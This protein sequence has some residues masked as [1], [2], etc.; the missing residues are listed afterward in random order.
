MQHV[1]HYDRIVVRP[2]SGALGAEVEGV[3]LAD[4]DAATFGEIQRAF[5]DHLCLFF[6]GQALD[7]RSFGEFGRRFG[8]LSITYYVEPVEG[9]DAVHRI[10]REA[11]AQWGE[12]NFGDNWHIDQSVRK[13]PNSIFALYALEVPPYGGDTMFA[14]LYR[15]YEA[16]SPGMQALC[17][18][19][20]VM[21][22]SRGLYGADGRGGT[23]V[24][25]PMP[26]QAFNIS[27]DQIRAQLAAEME[28]P[29]VI[30]HPVTGRKALYITGPYCVRF[31]DMTEDE[32]K[33]LL[34]YLYQHAQRPEFTCRLRWSAGTVALMDNRCMLHF[35]VQD[36]VGHR[37]EML[38]LEV[39]GEEPV[40]PAGLAH[41]AE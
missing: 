14:N 8:K 38:R 5:A 21:H 32:S 13:V 1:A 40:G 10:V 15:A 3:D 37:R 7:A 26:T 11:D 2:I 17:D 41:A 9:S 24:K 4:L 29:M 39:E 28:H 20:V 27:E 34:D 33:P 35:A 16:L 19:L 30:V 18:R 22:S 31:K 6:R 36:Y 25:K 12:R 23:G